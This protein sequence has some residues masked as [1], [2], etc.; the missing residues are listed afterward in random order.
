LTVFDMR[1]CLVH[2]KPS[3]QNKHWVHFLNDFLF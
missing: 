3:G 1:A 2:I